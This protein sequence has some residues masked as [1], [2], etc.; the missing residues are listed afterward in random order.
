MQN[1]NQ[2]LLS[3]TSFH[4]N[5]RFLPPFAIVTMVSLTELAARISA[6]A[7]ALEKFQP[8]N[9]PFD[10]VAASKDPSTEETRQN[11]LDEI[12]SLHYNVLS[13]A[14]IIFK[15]STAVRLYITP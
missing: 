8:D 3:S 9:A 1:P 14:D 10:P 11:L 7:A 15:I 2:N 6:N 12:M 5:P 13:P 4:K